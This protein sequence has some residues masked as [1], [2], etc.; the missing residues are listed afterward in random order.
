MRN[1]ILALAAAGSLIFVAFTP[2]LA[3][4]M[5]CSDYSNLDRCPIYAGGNGN[6]T[7]L[8]SSNQV[9]PRHIRHAQSYRGGYLYH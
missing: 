6:S 9:P 5:Q 8:A 1:T 2:A 3:V 4:G 7:P